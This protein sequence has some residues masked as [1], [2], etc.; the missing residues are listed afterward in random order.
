[1]EPCCKKVNGSSVAV[2]LRPIVYLLVCITKIRETEG[3]DE[4]ARSEVAGGCECYCQKIFSHIKTGTI[5][6]VSAGNIGD[7]IDDA[8]AALLITL[9]VIEAFC[10]G[11]HYRLGIGLNQQTQYSVCYPK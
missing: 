4:R 8:I 11:S 6:N 3:P 7:V 2:S 5:M 10:R 1:M 9:M